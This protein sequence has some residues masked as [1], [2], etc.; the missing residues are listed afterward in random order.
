MNTVEAPLLSLGLIAEKRLRISYV[1]EP[2]SGVSKPMCYIY[3]N[4]I[5]SAVTAY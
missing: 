3:L 4:G 1:I 2:T 5:L